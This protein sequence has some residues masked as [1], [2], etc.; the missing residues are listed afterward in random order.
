L[1]WISVISPLL[2]RITRSTMAAFW[3]ELGDEGV[4]T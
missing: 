1:R 4:T 2:M 3:G